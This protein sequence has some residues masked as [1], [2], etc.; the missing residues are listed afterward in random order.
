MDNQLTI[1]LLFKRGK[2]DETGKHK[3]KVCYWLFS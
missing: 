3:V 1:L 2:P